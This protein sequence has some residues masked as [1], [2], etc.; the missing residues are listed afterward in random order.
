MLSGEVAKGSY[1]CESVGIMA[2]ICREAES[3]VNSF[4]YFMQVREALK[5]PLKTPETVAS[6]AVSSC[7]EQQARCVIVLTNSGTTARFIAK[8]RPPCPIVAVV[9]AS[10]SRTAR[11]LKLNSGVYAVTYDD[12]EGKKSTDERV[13][14][15]LDYARDHGWIESG[16][17]VVAVHKNVLYNIEMIILIVYEI[18]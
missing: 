2:R 7:Y 12:H 3:A 14:T 6:S 13:H 16:D 18:H 11:Q 4:Q 17:Y 10:S 8:F 15:G 1:P 9:G 5:K